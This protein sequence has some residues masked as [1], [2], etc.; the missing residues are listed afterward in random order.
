M[1]RE[2]E[3]K[4]EERET[5]RLTA[6]KRFFADPKTLASGALFFSIFTVGLMTAELGPSLNL[7]AEQAKT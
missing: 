4:R 1:K 2:R 6:I 3:R 5:G 7:L